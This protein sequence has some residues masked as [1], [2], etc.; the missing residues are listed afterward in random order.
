MAGFCLRFQGRLHRQAFPDRVLAGSDHQ[1]ARPHCLH[2]D[3]GQRLGAGR[4]SSPCRGRLDVPEAGPVKRVKVKARGTG[5]STKSADDALP[6]PC[7]RAKAAWVQPISVNYS[8]MRC[9]LIVVPNTRVSCCSVLYCNSTTLLFA[10]Y[11][12]FRLIGIVFGL[13]PVIN[14][15]ITVRVVSCLPRRG[16]QRI[17]EIFH[18]LAF[19]CHQSAPLMTTST[20]I[21]GNYCK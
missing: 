13:D 5:W 16:Q 12:L 14:L 4:V 20:D 10:L 7:W 11:W 17:S 6:Q 15:T 21:F 9:N 18:F 2:K 3:E 1:A 8:V 19:G